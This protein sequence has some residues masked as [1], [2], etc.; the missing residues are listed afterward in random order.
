VGGRPHHPGVTERTKGVARVGPVAVVQRT[1]DQA[2]QLTEG[3]AA[4]DGV[5]VVTPADPG[6]SA[7]IVCVDIPGTT[8]GNAVVALREAGIVASATPYRTSYLRLGP[9]IVTTPEQVD[10]AVRAVATLV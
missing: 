10:A 6:V 1:V 4:V 3:L 5:E 7:G 9:S 8:P 2:T